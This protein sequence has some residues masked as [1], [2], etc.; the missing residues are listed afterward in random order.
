MT[1][2]G[3]PKDSAPTSVQRLPQ[4][5]FVLQVVI[6]F[7]AAALTPNHLSYVTC[8]LMFGLV[9]SQGVLAGA[10]FTLGPGSLVLRFIT[11]PLWVTFA[12]AIG[13]INGRSDDVFPIL[14]SIATGASLMIACL[15]FAIR[16]LLG[17]RLGTTSDSGGLPLQ[18]GLKHLMFLMAAV[19][20]LAAGFSR[21]K[22]Q[23]PIL[24]L[25]GIGGIFAI[26][27]ISSVGPDLAP[28]VSPVAMWRIPHSS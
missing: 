12:A 21:F 27:L 11:V 16:L 19:S 14:L 1:D 18:Y 2:D 5:F 4:E 10:W 24:F 8:Q 26:G 22:E 15:L 3:L 25:A 17:W 13:G 9:I 6:L 28:T 7:A 20:V 23:L